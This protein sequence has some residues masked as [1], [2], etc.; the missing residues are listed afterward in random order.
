MF[1]YLGSLSLETISFFLVILFIYL[2]ITT[3]NRWLPFKLYH[4]LSFLQN[5]DPGMNMSWKIHFLHS[6]LEFF[7]FLIILTMKVMTTVNVFSSANKEYEQ[8]ISTRFFF[9]N[10]IWILYKYTGKL[11]NITFIEIIFE[12]SFIPFN[13]I[14]KM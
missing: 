13:F 8:I 1:K 14:I 3:F 6:H 9:I 12:V 5:Q 10:I 7:F 4:Y 11:N 2:F